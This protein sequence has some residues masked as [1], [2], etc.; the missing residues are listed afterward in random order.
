MVLIDGRLGEKDPCPRGT[1]QPKTTYPDVSCHRPALCRGPRKHLTRR[2][3][4]YKKE[5][6]NLQ[7]TLVFAFV[8]FLFF[9]DR[10]PKRF[11]P[12]PQNRLAGRG[13]STRLGWSNE[14]LAGGPDTEIQLGRA[15]QS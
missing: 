10:S 1:H 4:I 13:W 3:I 14:E 15:P 8:L 2:M 12:L 11:A 5:Q 6:Y 9:P 7:F